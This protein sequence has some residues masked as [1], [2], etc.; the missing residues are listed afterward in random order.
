MSLLLTVFNGWLFNEWVGVAVT[1]K[2]AVE[3]TSA[4]CASYMLSFLDTLSS[5]A[6]GWNYTKE[7]TVISLFQLK[8]NQT[9][10]LFSVAFKMY[11]MPAC[12]KLASKVQSSSDWCSVLLTGSI[13]STVSFVT[14]LLVSNTFIFVCLKQNANKN[15]KSHQLRPQYLSL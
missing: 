9:W 14:F 1:Y 6:L 7:A 13:K 10:L 2:A 8:E 5:W 11:W 15:P 12:F 3:I 4:T